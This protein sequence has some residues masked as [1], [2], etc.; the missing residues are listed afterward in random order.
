M[1]RDGWSYRKKKRNEKIVEVVD[2]VD[3]MRKVEG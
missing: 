2:V 1:G 3:D